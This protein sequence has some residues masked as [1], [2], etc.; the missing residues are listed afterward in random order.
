[1]P[2][3]APGHILEQDCNHDPKDEPD[4]CREPPGARVAVEN[5]IPESDLV[6]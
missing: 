3:V 1:M 6:Q 5:G 4:G 2:S